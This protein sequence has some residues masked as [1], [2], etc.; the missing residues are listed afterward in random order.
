MNNLVTN[1][2]DAR[3]SMPAR[4]CACVGM[5]RGVEVSSV[6]HIL[7]YTRW[8][9]WMVIPDLVRSGCLSRVNKGHRRLYYLTKKGRKLI[10]AEEERV[11]SESLA[12]LSRVR[13]CDLANLELV[14]QMEEELRR[15]ML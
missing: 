15:G 8:P 3:Y 7:G 14:E 11:R 4:V 10:A 6:A 9:V 2:N 1:L 12:F 13:L 5:F